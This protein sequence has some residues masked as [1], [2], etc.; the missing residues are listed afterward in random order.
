MLTWWR[1]RIVLG[2]LHL[3]LKIASV[4][5]RIWIDDQESDGPVKDVVIVKLNG[6][7][8]NAILTLK[9]QSVNIPR[10]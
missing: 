7:S 4:V 9:G 2:K 10:R 8:A 6:Q 5:Q 3:P 1:V